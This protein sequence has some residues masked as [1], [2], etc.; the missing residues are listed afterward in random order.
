[1]AA[2]GPA[3]D[4][5]PEGEERG[6]ALRTAIMQVSVVRKAPVSKLL[7]RRYCVLVAC[8]CCFL[9]AAACRARPGSPRPMRSSIREHA[10]CAN[11][12]DNLSGPLSRPPSSSPSEGIWR[13]PRSAHAT[14]DMQRIR[15]FWHRQRIRHAAHRH[16]IRQEPDQQHIWHTSHM[17]RIW[18][19]LRRQQVHSARSAW[20]AYLTDIAHGVHPAC[21]A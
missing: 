7:S 20:P 17:Q 13:T 18:H 12:S 16:H 11:L 14:S 6:V 5:P 19:N 2:L 3:R 9:A 1:M 8:L 15:H 21:A 4:W 10:P